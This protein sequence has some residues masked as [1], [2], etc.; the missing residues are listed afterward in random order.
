MVT[1][2]FFHLVCFILFCVETLVFALL[3]KNDFLKVNLLFSL[4]LSH[5][6]FD[7][8]VFFYLGNTHFKTILSSAAAIGTAGGLVVRCVSNGH[9]NVLILQW[10]GAYLWILVSRRLKLRLKLMTLS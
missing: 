7:E 2:T 3:I 8:I 10:P 9:E 5:Q 1:C 6:E 4:G